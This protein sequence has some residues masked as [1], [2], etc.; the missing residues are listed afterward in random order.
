LQAGAVNST[1]MRHMQ[2]WC[3]TCLYLSEIWN[4]LWTHCEWLKRV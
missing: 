4:V 1:A 2:I 3:M